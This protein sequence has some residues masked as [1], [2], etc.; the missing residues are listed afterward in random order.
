MTQEDFAHFMETGKSYISA[1]ESGTMNPTLD[2]MV[3]HASFFG[4]EHYELSNPKLPVPSFAQ[5][6][7]A[8][9][10]AINQL[11]K[12]QQAAKEKV[13]AVK[14]LEREEGKPGRAKQLHTLVAAGFFKRSR[15]AKEAFAKLN[16]TVA[17]RD[18]NAHN[19]EIGKI[20]VTLSSGRFLKLLDKFE[21]APGSTAVRFVMKDP[22]V[23]NYLDRQAGSKDLAADAE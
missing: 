12:R 5:L 18:L 20:N 22:N 4:V 13:T 6:P 3:R 16:P 15:T 11:L 23:I 19:E 1:L 14:Q 21:P 10:K 8:T 7:A 2:M 9:R 17:K